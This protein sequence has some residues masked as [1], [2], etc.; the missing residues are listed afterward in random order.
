MPGVLAVGLGESVPGKGEVEEDIFT[1]SEHPPVIP[2][3]TM[4]DALARRAD[5]GYFKSLETP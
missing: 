5:P 4:L 3:D 1:I 2:G